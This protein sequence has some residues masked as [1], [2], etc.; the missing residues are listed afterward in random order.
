MNEQVITIL[1]IEDDWHKPEVD[2][3]ESQKLG[4]STWG[5]IAEKMGIRLTR[6]SI[7]WF[8]TDG[9]VKFWEFTGRSWVKKEEKLVP[10]VC[11]DKSRGYDELSLKEIPEAMTKKQRINAISPVINDP[12]FSSL[13]NNKLNQALIFHKYMPSSRLVL[14]GEVIENKEKEML[15]LKS[16]FGSGGKQ[17]KIT[18]EQNIKIEEKLLLQEFIKAKSGDVLKD[19]RIVF[20]GEKPQYALSRRAAEGSYHTNFHQGA[21]IEFLDLNDLNDIISYSKEIS[22][23]LDIFPKKVFSMDYL[24]AT[25]TGKPYLIEINTMPGLDVFDEKSISI[26]EDYLT[27]LSKYLL[28]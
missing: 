15:V 16:F 24:I 14:P 11:Y 18:N 22:K 27:E 28:A 7:E 12:L 19:I 25:E 4:Y 10:S 23:S 21:T 3:S 1:Y 2:H 13:L 5:K 6:V 20:L 26:L 8:H 9:F 17:V